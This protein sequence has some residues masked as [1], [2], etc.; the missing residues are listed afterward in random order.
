[1]HTLYTKGSN[2]VLAQLAACGDNVTTEHGRRGD[3]PAYPAC[4]PI[5]IIEHGSMPDQRVFVSM[6][7]DVQSALVVL[8]SN[9]RWG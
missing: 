5:A 4:I 2:R 8:G 7:E 6:L 9:D 3:G 1:M